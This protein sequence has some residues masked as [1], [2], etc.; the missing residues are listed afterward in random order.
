MLLEYAAPK[1]FNKLFDGMDGQTGLVGI[2]AQEEVK[3]D[4]KS[5]ST[6][7]T[8]KDPSPEWASMSRWLAMDPP[9]A[10][11]DLRDYMWV[12]RDRLGST[13]SGTTMIPPI[14]RAVLRSVLSEIGDVAGR[15]DMHNL[16]PSEIATLNQLLVSHAQR[17]PGEIKAYKA[18]IELADSY[19]QFVQEFKS[20]I[21][22]IPKGD[23]PPA[24]AVIVVSNASK[25]NALGVACQAIIVEN[26][27]G[28]TPF[29]K[30]L[31]QKIK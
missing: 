11:V 29:D 13:M 4:S 26:Q 14:V 20:L 1:L 3:P 25:A 17:K 23:L 10:T 7:S 18:L 27:T 5:D 16:Q 8:S 30:A 31:K 22:R 24:L 19:R 2:L 15:R 28:K 6:A 21:D 9:L 12:T